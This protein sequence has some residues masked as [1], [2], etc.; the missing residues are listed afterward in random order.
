MPRIAEARPPAEPSSAEQKRRYRRMLRAAAALGAEHGLERVQMHDVARE[1]GVAIATL[2]RYFPSKTDLFAAVLKARMDRA[3]QEIR[4]PEPGQP[5]HE[6]VAAMLVTAGRALLAQRKL[7]QAMLQANNGVQ[8]SMAQ[9]DSPVT[10]AFHGMLL[11]AAG[12]DRP[13]EHDLRLV[14]LV[15]Q[16]WYG[17][18]VSVL[19]GHIT[20]AEAEADVHL[21][22]ELL[23]GQGFGADD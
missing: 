20:D 21:A 3:R 10:S 23:L 8:L 15:E 13:T 14:R 5:R 16:T 1:A 6:S 7:A 2:Y 19:N 18:L 9:A 11:A 12:I 17:V 4:G 22:C